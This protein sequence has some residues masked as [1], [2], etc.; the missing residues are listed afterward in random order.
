MHT[1]QKATIIMIGGLS[2]SGKTSTAKALQAALAAQNKPFVHLPIDEFI[3]LLPPEW[4]N[5]DTSKDIKQ[6]PDGI[7]LKRVDD[8]KGPKVIIELGP[9]GMKL[10]QAY[11]P[12]VATI[13]SYGSDIIIDGVFST[14]YLLGAVKLFSNYRVYCI[15]IRCPLEIT[16][17]RERQR[18]AIGGFIGLSRGYAETSDVHRHSHYDLLVD[19]SSKTPEQAAQEIL[20][21]TMQECEPQALKKL[22][23]ATK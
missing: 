14:P 9:I 21:F 10:G 22:L 20:E 8:E 6:N 23:Q 5:P 17:M 19:T 7:V 16:E 11:L 18:G 12:V 1:P 13:A 2:S 15:S 3:G 4:F